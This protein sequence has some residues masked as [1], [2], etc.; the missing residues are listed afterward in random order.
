[1]KNKNLQLILGF[2]LLVSFMISCPVFGQDKQYFEKGL[3][4]LTATD[5]DGWASLKTWVYKWNDEKRKWDTVISERST[6]DGRVDFSLA[7]GVYKLGMSYRE[8]DPAEWRE[9][10]N[11]DLAEELSLHLFLG[12]DKN[13]FL[14]L[15]FED[16]NFNKRIRTYT[17]N[18]V[19]V[20]EIHLPKF[21]SK[22]FLSIW[23]FL[24][25]DGTIYEFRDL[26]DGLHVIR[27][28][29]QE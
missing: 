13:M 5:S 12:I 8:A 16:N 27:W 18:Y 28:S 10:E 21:A 6:R 29:R 15:L 22:Y 24:R 4:R 9:I 7:P 17:I 20:D 2:I 1:M 25:S 3:L 11:V 19:L 23:P 14:Y 26:E